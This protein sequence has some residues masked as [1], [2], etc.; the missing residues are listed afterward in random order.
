[1]SDSKFDRGMAVRRAVLGDAHVDASMDNATDLTR[2]FQHYLT[3]N[4]W[5][6]IWTRPVWSARRAACSSL[7]SLRRSGVWKNS[8]CICVRAAIPA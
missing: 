8:N 1:M 3:E 4:V 7:R 2:D 6:D 5:G